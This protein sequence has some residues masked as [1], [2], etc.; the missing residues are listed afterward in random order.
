MGSA[1]DPRNTHDMR[2]ARD[3]IAALPPSG[4]LVAD[5]GYD[6]DDLRRWLAERG[7]AYGVIT[8]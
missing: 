2:V 4:E 6:S 8:G 3:C 7:T 1:A 5:K